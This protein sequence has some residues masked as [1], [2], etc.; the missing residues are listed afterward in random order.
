MQ[1]G[2][3]DS[4]PR[5]GVLALCPAED[6]EYRASRAGVSRLIVYVSR[7]VAASNDGTYTYEHNA[8]PLQK[9]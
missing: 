4:R 5:G 2:V 7:R 9:Y 6:I 1:A 8:Q 3:S